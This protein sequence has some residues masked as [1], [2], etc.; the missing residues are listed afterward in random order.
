MRRIVEVIR[1]AVFMAFLSGPILACVF[2]K[3]GTP[4]GRDFTPFPLLTA[5]AN[6][7]PAGRLTLVEAVLD[8][9][10]VKR[11]AIYLHNRL[12]YDGLRYIDTK[13][14]ISGLDGWLFFKPEF[15]A[16]ECLG[17]TYFAS[18]LAK[19]DGMTDL[20]E[21]AGLQLVFAVS[22][23]KSSIYPE[24]LHPLARIY[25]NCKA[26]NGILWR[27]IA[28]SVAPRL[29]DHAEPI[30]NYKLKDPS[31]LLYFPTDTHWTPIGSALARRQLV[32]ALSRRDPAGLPQPHTASLRH[33]RSTDLR[34]GMLLL[35]RTSVVNGLD[36]TPEAQLAGLSRSLDLGTTV[37]LYDSFVGVFPNEYRALFPP[38]QFFQMN[39]D[40][41]T[42][43]R[44]ADTTIVHPVE[45]HFFHF[46]HDGGVLTPVFEA[47]VRRNR[48]KAKNCTFGAA[49]EPREDAGH[50]GG[51]LGP[52]QPSNLGTRS[53]KATMPTAIA[54]QLPCIKIELL[55]SADSLEIALPRN[56]RSFR[57]P[58]KPGMQTVTLVLPADVAERQLEIGPGHNIESQDVTVTSVVVGTVSR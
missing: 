9:S 31:H 43:L 19:V 22:P 45:R 4:Y 35:G 30:L 27:G 38:A 5:V 56:N 55:A 37:Y 8:R 46:L 39:E 1:I 32:A 26:E 52:R 20:A 53:W 7:D 25:W 11:S 14:V 58:L 34:D 15:W 48:E 29:L 18:A 6:L 12:L 41:A 54:G 36:P 13:D 21:A 50:F 24:K 42:A 2:F 40:Y 47:I 3:L 57:L 16:G 33:V 28:K 44:T 23:D 49:S 17:E 10:I 51:E